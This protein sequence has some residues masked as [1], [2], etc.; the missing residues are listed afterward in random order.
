MRCSGGIT[1]LF[2][3]TRLVAAVAELGSF[4]VARTH[5]AQGRG[6]GARGFFDR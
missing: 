1:S 5:R 6:G 4:V 2:Q 3:S